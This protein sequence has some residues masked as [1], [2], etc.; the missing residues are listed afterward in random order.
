MGIDPGTLRMGYAVL[1]AQQDDLHPL[2]WGALIAPAGDALGLRLHTLYT[3]LLETLEAYHPDWV[4]IEEPFV[5]KNARTA[6]AIG[7]AQG[8]ALVAAAHLGIAVAGYPPRK[9]K[10]ATTGHGA[11]TKE[12]VQRAIILHLGM[13]QPLLPSDASDAMAVALCHLQAVQVES[14]V[15]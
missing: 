14:I 5:S 13:T 9:V 7:Q 2:A 11:A 6:M 8:L 3:R 15:S 10:L 1:E 12:Q 4:A